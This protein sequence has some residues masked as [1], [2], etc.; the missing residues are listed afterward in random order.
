VCH[1]GH[2]S[3]F[4]FRHSVVNGLGWPRIPDLS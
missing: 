2:L 4:A 1:G 3:P